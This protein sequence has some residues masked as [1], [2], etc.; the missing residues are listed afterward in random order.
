[1]KFLI[2]L[3]LYSFLGFSIDYKGGDIHADD[4]KWLNANLYHGK[5]QRGGFQKFTDSY[6]ELEFGGRSGIV[7]YYGYVDF[8]DILNDA[9]SSDKYNQ[10]NSFAKLDLRFSFDSIFKKD[11]AL[12]PVKE[13]YLALEM[14]DGDSGAFGGLR[15]F[16]LGLGT[17][18]EIPW[19]GLVGLNLQARHFVENFGASNEG[20]WDGYVFHMNWFKPLSFFSSGNF[21]SFQ[22]Y[23][24]YEFDSEIQGVDRTKT[25][26]Q[27]YLGVWYHS[28]YYA[29]GYG[30][31]L[32]ENMNNFKHK[33]LLAGSGPVI[34]STGLGH[35]LNITYKF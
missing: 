31:K 32:Y 20:K 11:F 25:A 1:M 10:D 5:N 16:W 13:W 14:M 7:D 24:D 18:T 34:D 3:S 23:L 9:K 22:G 15:V 27:T 8:L 6:L 29:I 17:D 30:A 28:K 33:E 21:L 19:L 4:S 12:G 2:L 26:F 35:Y